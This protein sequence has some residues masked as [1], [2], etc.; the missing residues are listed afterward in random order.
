MKTYENEVNS[1]KN[2]IENSVNEIQSIKLGLIQKYK[3]LINN[4]LE[5][6]D[7][8]VMRKKMMKEGRSNK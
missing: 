3:K 8:L 7:I 4:E 6:Y 2:I 5:N 1:L